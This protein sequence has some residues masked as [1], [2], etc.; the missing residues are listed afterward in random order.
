M[1]SHVTGRANFI[2]SGNEF[3][4]KMLGTSKNEESEESVPL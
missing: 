3:A 4:A 1:G 2:D